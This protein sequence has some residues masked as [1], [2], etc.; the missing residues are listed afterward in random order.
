MPFDEFLRQRIFD[1]LEMND[2]YFYL[3]REKANRLV[4]A[5]RASEKGWKKKSVT[6]YDPD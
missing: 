3:S 5:Q 2:A 4:V 1:L 6:F